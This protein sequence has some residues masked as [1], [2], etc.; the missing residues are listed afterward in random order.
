MAVG[1]IFCANRIQDVKGCHDYVQAALGPTG[2][3]LDCERIK[4][5]GPRIAE[6]LRWIVSPGP[7]AYLQEA[8]VFVTRG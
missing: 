6:M 5:T 1:I 2:L 8:S 7:A 4:A 3:K